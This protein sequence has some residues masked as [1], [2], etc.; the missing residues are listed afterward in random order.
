LFNWRYL[1]CTTLSFYT[2][3]NLATRF[4]A[5]VRFVFR[6]SAGPF[7]A[8][9]RVKAT[10]SHWS[11][12]NGL[13]GAVFQRTYLSCRFSAPSNPRNAVIRYER[14]FHRRWLASHKAMERTFHDR[15]W[16]EE[17][18]QDT[19]LSRPQRQGFPVSLEECSR[20]ESLKAAS[21]LRS[22][23]SGSSAPRFDWR[24]RAASRA[25]S[26]DHEHKVSCDGKDAHTHI[27]RLVPQQLEIPPGGRFYH[28]V[29]AYEDR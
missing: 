26:Q 14:T 6:N 17:A 1:L 4:W 3:L 2:T 5:D 22:S 27:K 11:R 13:R 12:T 18:F 21:P 29:K 8:S 9:P 20:D 7:R 28:E 19:M 15:S 16:E 23:S 24:R 25:P 10:P